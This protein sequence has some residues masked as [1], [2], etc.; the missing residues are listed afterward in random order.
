MNSLTPLPKHTHSYIQRGLFERHKLLF[1]LMLTNKVLVSAGK[2][3]RLQACPASA[4]SAR[5]C[6]KSAC[7]SAGFAHQ[8]CCQTR[9]G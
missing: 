6:G 5:R 8:W 7:I 4:A 3:W 2:V 9:P 1:A